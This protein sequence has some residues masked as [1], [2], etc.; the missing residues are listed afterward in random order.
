MTRA[1]RRLAFVTLLLA[2]VLV[3][4]AAA[5]NCDAP[6][7]TAAVDQYCENVPSAS[8]PGSDSGSIPGPKVRR[9]VTRALQRSGDAGAQLDRFLGAKSSQSDAR[10]ARRAA[11]HPI[12]SGDTED[13][14][15]PSHGRSPAHSS[16]D[17]LSAVQSAVSAGADVGSGF[18]WLLLALGL[19]ITGAAW[20]RY[21]RGSNS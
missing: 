21:R 15:P 6:P 18:V 16:T 2:A 17:P 11:R 12:A 1:F 5:E 8:G 19:V 9:T 14:R 7:G 20:L 13:L 3:P 4:S 10:S